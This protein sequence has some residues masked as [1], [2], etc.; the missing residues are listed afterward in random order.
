M[1]DL[2]LNIILK[3]IEEWK[4][5]VGN[6]GQVDILF[7]FILKKVFDS[8]HKITIDISV[9][10]ESFDQSEEF[11]QVISVVEW[12]IDFPHYS[13]DLNEVSHDVGEY[14]YTDQKD[15]WDVNSLKVASWM[16]VSETYGRQGGER[17]VSHNDYT[18]LCWHIF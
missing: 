10:V 11:G 16:E 5:I 17:K 13:Y 9:I 12:S 14:R 18:V 15:K 1:I 8:K 3:L 7:P 2:A 4:I 6:N